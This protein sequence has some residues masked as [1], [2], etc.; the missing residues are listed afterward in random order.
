VALRNKIFNYRR[1]QAVY[2][3]HVTIAGKEN[4]FSN[5]CNNV[6]Q[7]I[8]LKELQNEI[9]FS[10]DHMKPKYKEVFVLHEQKDCTIKRISTILNRPIDT[11]EKQL[12]KAVFL[13]RDHLREKRIIEYRD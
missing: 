1:S 12:R 5:D 11:V 10:L 6:E 7:S 2:K 4:L 8:N 13:I 9:S 3:K